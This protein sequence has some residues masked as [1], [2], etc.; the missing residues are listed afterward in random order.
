MNVGLYFT[1]RGD[2]FVDEKPKKVLSIDLL[3]KC[4]RLALKMA[5]LINPYLHYYSYYYYECQSL[6]FT[7]RRDHF[8]DDEK[9]KKKKETLRG[10]IYRIYRS[11]A[12]MMHAC[13]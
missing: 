9:P 13:I 1:P 8:V 12:S 2:H 4:M 11:Q 3:Y 6:Y 10:I 5:L 7:P